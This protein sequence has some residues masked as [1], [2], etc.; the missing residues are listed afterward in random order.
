MF[1]VVNV[2]VSGLSIGAEVNERELTTRVLRLPRKLQYRLMTH[3]VAIYNWLRKNASFKVNGSYV[4]HHSKLEEFHRYFRLQKEKFNKKVYEIY[5]E[6]KRTWPEQKH[7]L[8]NDLRKRRQRKKTMAQ[9]IAKLN[10]LDPPDNPEELARM[11]YSIRELAD[12]ISP[13]YST[14]LPADV[15]AYQEERRK[16]IQAEI[17]K[18]YLDRLSNLYSRFKEVEQEKKKLEQHIAN[19]KANL[20]IIGEKEERKRK[21]LEL[22]LRSLSWD[23]KKV[24]REMEKTKKE[25]QK[26]QQEVWELEVLGVEVEEI[27]MSD[28]WT[29]LFR[30]K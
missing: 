4:L 3:K 2:N 5:E 1:Y 27:K 11:E 6:L 20:T 18:Q 30:Q 21:K 10:R 24:N 23:L 19:V 7:R 28:I 15:V 22:K 8:I 9:L 29:D 12:W 14:T 25:C 13:R 26:I 16:H 17:R